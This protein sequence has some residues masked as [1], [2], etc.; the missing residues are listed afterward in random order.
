VHNFSPNLRYAFLQENE[1][2]QCVDLT[3]NRKMI[4]AERDALEDRRDDQARGF[5]PGSR[6]FYFETVLGYS[7]YRTADFSFLCTLQKT[8]VVIV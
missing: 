2:V 3:T 7:F 8:N 5:T 6:Y 4:V 1:V